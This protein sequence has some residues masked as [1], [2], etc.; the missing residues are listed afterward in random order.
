MKKTLQWILFGILLA[1][2]VVVGVQTYKTSRSLEQYSRLEFEVKL[3]IRAATQIRYHLQ[4]VHL[5]SSHLFDSNR[6]LDSWNEK[7]DQL[8]TAVEAA[9]AQLDNGLKAED[10]SFLS[11][12]LDQIY[13][14]L[15]SLEDQS[16]AE[17]KKTLGQIRDLSRQIEDYAVTAE[18]VFVKQIAQQ[19]TDLNSGRFDNSSYFY[20]LSFVILCSFAC[21][22]LV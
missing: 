17:R 11:P 14:H 7:M 20:I 6:P 18:N 2:T 12:L 9:I 19:V 13:Q 4:K 15:E 5:I 1:S 3:G 21:L 16:P 22:A 10:K 8:F